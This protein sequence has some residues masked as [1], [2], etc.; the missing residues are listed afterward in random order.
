VTS[1]RA[2]TPIVGAICRGDAQLMAQILTIQT[3][4]A[5]LAMPVVISRVR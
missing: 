4:G 5:A 2:P 3:I 1:L